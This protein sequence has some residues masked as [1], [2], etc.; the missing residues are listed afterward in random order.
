MLTDN[1]CHVLPGIDDGARDS[2][3][4]LEMLEIMKSQGVERVV[5]T[6][7]FYAHR[8]KSVKDFIRKRQAAYEK[9]REV[10]PLPVILGAEVAIERGVSDLEDIRQLAFE[11]T[12]VILL[13]LPYGSFKDWMIDEIDSFSADLGLDVMLAHVHRCAHYYNAEEMERILS[14]N[15]IYQMN[16]E[17]VARL[18]GKR[19]AKHLI[20][21]GLPVAFGSDAH[22]LTD[23]RPN[24]DILSKKKFADYTEF[25]NNLIDRYS[26]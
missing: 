20:K 21:E 13:E 18:K 10:S 16:N 6:P 7:H 23:R 17:A 12:S 19:M 5:A 22:N 25:S 3:M 24:W 14:L 11:G 15:V 2:E 4:A 8:E 26:I 9:I 1:H